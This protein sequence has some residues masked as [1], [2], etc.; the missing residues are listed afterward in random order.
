MEFVCPI[1]QAT[2]NIPGDNLENP[3]T[4]TTCQNCGTILLVDHNG[5]IDAYK[6]PFKDSPGLKISSTQTTIDREKSVSSLLTQGQGVR[7]WTAISVVGIIVVVIIA[8][9]FILL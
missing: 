2:G 9:A 7:D 3:V 6:S 1:C 8:A 4:K 5:N